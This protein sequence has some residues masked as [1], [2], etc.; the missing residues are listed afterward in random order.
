MDGVTYTT[1]PGDDPDW[2]L[3]IGAC[4]W[5]REREVGEAE[6]VTLRFF[7]KPR[8]LLAVSLLSAV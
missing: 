5:I 4:G 1:C 6:R 3:Q 8:D 7:D 2:L